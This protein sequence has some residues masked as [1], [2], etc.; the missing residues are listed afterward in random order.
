[1]TLFFIGLAAGVAYFI[2]KICRIYDPSQAQKYRYVNEVLTFFGKM[3]RQHTTFNTHL[4]IWDP[5]W[6][7]FVF[8]YPHQS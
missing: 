4:F 6:C 7:D 1:M 3:Y 2:F 8:A 5:S